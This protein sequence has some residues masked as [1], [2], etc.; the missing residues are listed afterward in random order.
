M[1]FTL[2]ANGSGCCYGN[3][4]FCDSGLQPFIRDSHV[5][6][7]EIAEVLKGRCHRHRPGLSSARPCS[8]LPLLIAASACV[9]RCSIGQHRKAI[10]E[11]FV[12]VSAHE[13]A[14]LVTDARAARAHASIGRR[15][16]GVIQS[17]PAPWRPLEPP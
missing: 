11:V 9:G 16:P 13:G 6:F 5:L 8:H 1:T 7:D 3:P 12:D 17:L 14:H 2:A 4:Q 15:G 10:A